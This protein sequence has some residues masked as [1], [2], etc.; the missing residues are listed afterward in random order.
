MADQDQ[1]PAQPKP[2]DFQNTSEASS[3]EQ[4]AT[5]SPSPGYGQTGFAPET[6]MSGQ[7]AGN[8]TA[9]GGLGQNQTGYGG[10]NETNSGDGEGVAQNAEQQSS[11]GVSTRSDNLGPSPTGGGQARS[12]TTGGPDLSKGLGD[13]NRGGGSF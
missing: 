6:G 5:A 7:I 3:A 4:N 10:D 9:G 8:D 12:A 1:K 13:S 2:A 11:Q